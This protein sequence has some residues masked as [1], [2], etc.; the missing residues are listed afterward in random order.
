MDQ[1][2]GL[3][4]FTNHRSRLLASWAV[5]RRALSLPY[6]SDRRATAIAL[7]GRAVVDHEVILKKAG[8]AV[9][10]DVV[11]KRT[12]PCPQREFEGLAYLCDEKLATR[13]SQSTRRRAGMNA[14]TEEGLIS[15]DVSQAGN[16]VAVHKNMLDSRAPRT[17]DAMEPCAVEIWRQGLGTDACQQGMPQG[18]TALPQH[19]PEAAWVTE[20]DDRSIFQY[21]VEMVMGRWWRSRVHDP[22]APRHAKVQNQR[23]AAA[24]KEEVFSASG[25]RSYGRARQDSRQLPRDAEPERT[26]AN[27]RPADPLA[28]QQRFEPAPGRLD[29]G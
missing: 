5:E 23:P 7:L 26:V 16:H 25:E 2:D 15:V 14:G 17:G 20:T 9:A 18:I 19:E 21:E 11:A 10:R 22:Q 1:T 4:L 24:I 27:D 3:A 12:A 6:P 13:A 28:D 8:L 29:F